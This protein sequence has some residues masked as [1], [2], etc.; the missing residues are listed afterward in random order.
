M[1]AHISTAAVFSAHREEKKGPTTAIVRVLCSWTITSSSFIHSYKTFIYIYVSVLTTKELG[2][3]WNE[4]RGCRME[5]RRGRVNSLVAFT[6]VVTAFI[7]IMKANA[8]AFSRF[9]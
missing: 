6:V 1:R 5:R 8:R 2:A 7:R 9:N 4:L 3:V